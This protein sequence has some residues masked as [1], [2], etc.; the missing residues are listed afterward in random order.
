[1]KIIVLGAGEVASRAARELVAEPDVS[2]V[3]VADR[4]FEAALQLASELGE[5]ALAVRLDANDHITLVAAVRGHDVAANGISS[6]HC[7][8]ARVAHAAIEARVPYVSL[9]DDYD[10]V[11]AVLVLDDA[12]RMAGVTVLTGLG[13]TPGLSN[14]LARKAAEQFDL[15]DEI[16][17]AWGGSA[18]DSRDAV[19][20]RVVDSFTGP[21]PSFHGGQRVD[22]APGSGKE[23]IL[24]PPPVGKVNC[25]HLRHP[26]VITLPRFLPGLRTV[27]LKGGLSEQPLKS[28]ALGLG[29]LQLAGTPASREFLG[30]VI[31][32][33]LPFLRMLNPSVE[34]YSA[35]RVDVGGWV[36]GAYRQVSYGAAAPMVQLA[37][38][39]LAMGALMLGRREVHRPGVVAPEAC[40][41][42]DPFLAEL[43]RRGVTIHD[44][45][46]RWPA[47]TGMKFAPSAAS[48]LLAALAAWFFLG[49]LHRRRPD[50]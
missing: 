29:R 5:K 26:E 39:P 40:I 20:L 21:V 1:M 44:M 27:T 48:L 8:E 33:A 25:Y 6:L 31:R 2:T 41:E 15:A 37:S 28:L 4:S 10:A 43:G 23:A 9:C 13:W 24:F 3:T 46:G 36:G 49:W 45:T 50:R 16:N 22:M 7:R 11:R 42:P 35:V 34:P 19:F 12:A 32:T 18:T 30:Q 17:I 38:L 47:A 14:V